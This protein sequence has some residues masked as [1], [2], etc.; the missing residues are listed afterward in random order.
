MKCGIFFIILFYLLAKLFWVFRSAKRRFKSILA[1]IFI[2]A[3]IYIHG[4]FYSKNT[5]SVKNIGAQTVGNNS[6]YIVPLM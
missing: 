1:D 3:I 5:V 4:V 2:E 6:S